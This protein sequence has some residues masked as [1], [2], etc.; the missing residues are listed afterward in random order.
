MK[1]QGLP[2]TTIV[3]IV[4][5]VVVL[6]AVLLFFFGA[7]GRPSNTVNTQ[8]LITRCNTIAEQVQNSNPQNKTIAAS[9]ATQFGFCKSMP[10]YDNKCCGNVTH[11]Q[12]ETQNGPCTLSCTSCDSSGGSASCS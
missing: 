10:Q 1:S 11:P 3:I 9:L 12:I 4:V 6:A 2:I 5:A 8:N 7:F